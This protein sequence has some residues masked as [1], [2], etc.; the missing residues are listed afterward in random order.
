MD[1]LAALGPLL[2]DGRF[3]AFWSIYVMKI[4]F[5]ILTCLFSFWKFFMFE[6]P[7][8]GLLALVGP[9]RGLQTTFYLYVL[10]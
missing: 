3:A 4:R 6:G 8:Y 7:L 10:D 2:L 1:H 5:G 9:P